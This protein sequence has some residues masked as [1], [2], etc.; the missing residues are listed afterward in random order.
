MVVKIFINNTTLATSSNCT[1]GDIR[2]KGGAN[3]LEG[4]VEVCHDDLWG[5]VCDHNWDGVDAGVACRQLG[6]LNFRKKHVNGKLIGDI[7]FNKK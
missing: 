5:T 7:N 2:L 3:E 6:F 1:T 4:R